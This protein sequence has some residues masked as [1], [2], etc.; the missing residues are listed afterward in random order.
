VERFSGIN[1]D[2]NVVMGISSPLGI[3]LIFLLLPPVDSDCWPF[4]E[5]EYLYCDETTHTTIFPYFFRS[6]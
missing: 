5:A 4:K 1:S 2:E 3:V 6:F